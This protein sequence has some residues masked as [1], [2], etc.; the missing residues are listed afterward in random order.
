MHRG[1]GRHVASL[2]VAG[3]VMAGLVVPANDCSGL[4]MT[5]LVVASLGGGSGLVRRSRIIAH[6]VVKAL[7]VLV[8]RHGVSAGGDFVFKG[9]YSVVDGRICGTGVLHLVL[10]GGD[11]LV[12]SLVLRVDRHFCFSRLLSNINISYINSQEDGFG[13]GLYDITT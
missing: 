8:Q 4:V 11:L 6:H 12:K 2:H 3:F 1:L 5:R 13:K 7:K 9:G 10:H